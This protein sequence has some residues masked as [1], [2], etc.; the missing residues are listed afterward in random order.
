M[1]SEFPFVNSTKTATAESLPMFREYAWDFDENHF[2]L[3][4]NGNMILLEGND[5]L[6]VWIVKALRTER[7]SYLAYT[8]N[9]GFSGKQLIGKVISVGERRSE[10][11]REI[12]E[13][14]MVNPWIKA[15]NS[16]NFTETFNG[17]DLAI[18]IDIE[19]VYGKL[20]L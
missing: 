14:L 20:S 17:K 10:L 2:I 3:D 11:R 5:A 15:I 1:S 8:W 19:S 13:T 18:D 12:I 9:F 4:G 7:F 6:K 16:I